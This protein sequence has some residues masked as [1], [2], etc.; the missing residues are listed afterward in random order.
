MSFAKAYF[1]TAIPF[2]IIDAVWIGLFVGGYYR[3]TVGH[4]LLETPNFVPAGLFYLAYAAGIVF[5]AVQP[6]IAAQK[7]KTALINGGVLG[8]IAYGT[9]TL[10]NYSVL[11]G[12][13]IELVVSDILWGTFLTG[14]SAGCGYLFARN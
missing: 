10:T 6:A 4:L 13:T 5:L 7:L 11:Q 3:E 1:G 2:L 14:L 8:A 9:F 12:W